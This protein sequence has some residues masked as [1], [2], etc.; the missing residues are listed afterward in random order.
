MQG[1]APESAHSSF[2]QKTSSGGSPALLP[3]FFYPKAPAFYPEAPVK[4][5][6][7]RI[8]TFCEVKLC[9]N[10]HRKT[11]A[12]WRQKWRKSIH[13]PSFPTVLVRRILSL[14]KHHPMDY[15]PYCLALRFLSSSFLYWLYC[16]VRPD[17]RCTISCFLRPLSMFPRC[18]PFET[19]LSISFS[20]IRLVW[21]SENGL[22]H[23]HSHPAP[24]RFPIQTMSGFYSSGTSRVHHC[25]SSKYPASWFI[26]SLCV[27]NC[28][29]YS[30][31]TALFASLW[32]KS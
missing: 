20:T 13:L 1:F 9:R 24:L 21:W 26:T 22:F 16:D 30:I 2:P 29:S 14:S 3:E 4:I 25:R 8:R 28:G 23:P 10:V 18:L 15:P 19:Y 31:V 5:H 6:P 11:C 12:K 17:L 32:S 7:F 27:L